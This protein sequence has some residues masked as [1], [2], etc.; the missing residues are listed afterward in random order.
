MITIAGTAHRSFSFPADLTTAFEFYSDM[1]R[2]FGFLSHI[3]ILKHYSEEQYRMAYHS[4]ELGI[5]RIQ[6]ICNIQAELD[7]KTSVIRI[8][9]LKSVPAIQNKA[10]LY[11]LTAQGYFTSDSIFSQQDGK[12]EIDYRLKLNAKLPVPHGVRFMPG[13]VINNIARG[14]TQRRLQE[15]VEGFIQRSTRAFHQQVP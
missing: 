10:G 13:P 11:S 6:I 14:I 4:T 5:Y 15:V 2:T 9:P 12:T 7:Q 1:Q 8:R 3:S